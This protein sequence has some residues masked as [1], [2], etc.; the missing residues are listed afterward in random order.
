MPYFQ[1][2]EVKI[3]GIW[4]VIIVRKVIGVQ[5]YML[6]GLEKMTLRLGK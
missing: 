1:V 2:F 3:G 5:E 6:A 4:V